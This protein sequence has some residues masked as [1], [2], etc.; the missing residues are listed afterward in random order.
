MAETMNVITE[1]VDD[2]PVLWASLERL[3]VADLV[4][5]YFVPHK[6]WQG[7]SPG[8]VLAGWLTHILSEAD[9][10]MNRVQDWAAKRLGILQGCLGME[11]RALDFSDDRLAAGLDLLSQDEAWAQFEQ[12]LNSRTL[13][14]YDLQAQRVRIDSTSA[15]GYWDVTAEGLFQYGHSKDHRPDLPQVKV[16]VAALDP[17]GAP[18]VT[19][20]V[21]GNQAD[22][23]LYIPAIEQVRAGIGQRGLLYIGDCKI[24]ALETRA[25]VHSGGDYYLGPFSRTHVPPATLDEYL[26]PVWEESQELTSVYP[27][28]AGEQPE[29]IAVGYERAVTVTAAVAG[30]EVSW[31]ERRLVV[32]SLAQAK[33]GEA[34]LRR[35]LAL[36]QTAI[37]ALNDRKQGKP[38]LATVTALREAAE[39]LC[40]RYQVT[41][42]LVLTYAEQVHERQVRQYGDSPAET[43]RD[44]QAQVAVTPDEA[45]LQQ[46]LRRL[47]WRVYG[48]N[49]SPEALSLAEVVWAYR[50]EYLVEHDFGRLKGKPLSLTPL[51]LQDEQRVTGLIRLL[52]L[53]LRVLTLLEFS[54]RRRLTETGEKL[55]GLYAGN[56]TRAT[57][58]PTAEA[59]L[60]A[61]KEVFL[62]SVTLEAHTY[63]HLTPLS[64][65][66]LKILNL[67]DF[68]ASIYTRLTANSANP[69]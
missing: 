43:R 26:Q 60:R 64:E 19:Q 40:R 47:G 17:L 8:K 51:Y 4:D 6:R 54:V 66:Q 44:C 18:L 37:R 62:N 69:P 12:A 56:P 55:A 31:V 53:G 46:A 24:L 14:V 2:I 29:P 23:P 42:L 65:L 67:L 57:A 59:L 68:P 16:V 45:A 35:H 61:F 9:H 39:A 33:A 63:G 25:Y 11:V 1:R 28:A 5:E 27:Q 58:H 10:R 21:P 49:F 38:R 30:K 34:T 7:L 20:V 41:G 36:A 13:R 15:N 32:R 48:T 22:D 50:A 3:E 52:S